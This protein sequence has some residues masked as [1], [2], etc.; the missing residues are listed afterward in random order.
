MECV[1]G[2]VVHPR[3]RGLR[4]DDDDH[5]PLAHQ[6]RSGAFARAERSSPS[7]SRRRRPASSSTR[8]ARARRSPASRPR[9]ST[10][11]RCRSCTR[12]RRRRWTCSPS[13]VPIRHRR[14]AN[15]CRA[16]S[17][18]V[19]SRSSRRRSSARRTSRCHSQPTTTAELCASDR[20]LPR[21]ARWRASIAATSA[22]KPRAGKLDFEDLLGAGDPHLRDATRRPLERFTRALPRLHRR[23]VPGRQP[24]PADAARPL[25]RR[26]RRPLRRR[27]RLP[28][29]LRASPAPRP[30]YLLGDAH[31]LRAGRRSIRL[32]RNYRSTP[33]VLELANRL[34]P[35]LGGVPK[36]LP[37]RRARRSRCRR[38]ERYD[39]ARAK[40][41]GRRGGSSGFIAAGMPPREIACSTAIKARSTDYELALACAPASRSRWRRRLPASARRCARLLRRLRLAASTES[42]RAWSACCARGR[43]R[44]RARSGRAESR[45]AHT[46]AVDLARLRRRWPRPSR[47]ASTP[48]ASSSPTCASAS[49][50]STP[51][52]TPCACSTYHLAKGLEWDAVFLP[53]LEERELPFFRALESGSVAEE[54]RLF[55]VGLTRARTH[56]FLT[57]DRHRK[58]SRFIDELEPDGPRPSRESSR[59]RRATCRAPREGGRGAGRPSP[60][61]SPGCATTP[62]GRSSGRHDRAAADRGAF[63][64]SVGDGRGQR[65][66]RL[67]LGRRRAPRTRRRRRGGAADAATRARRSWTSAASRR[68]PA[69]A[70][71]RSTRS[72]AASFPC[73]RG[74]RAL[75]VSIDT[76]KAEVARR[77]LALGAELVNDVTAL[78]GDPELAA[79]VADGGRLR[80]PHAHA[81]RAA[82]DAGRPALRRRRRP[83]SRRSSRSGWR[84]PSPRASR[85]ERVCLDPGIGFGKTVAHNLE[86]VRR[87]DELV[88][89]GR[90]VVVGF[91]RKSSLGRILGDPTATTGTLAASVG[92]AVAAF[93]RGATI[94]RVHDVREHVEALRVARGGRRMT[95]ELRGLELFGHHGVG[96]EERERGQLSSTT[97]SS[98]SASAARD[99]RIEDAVDY[100][101]VA[102]TVR[103]VSAEPRFALLEALS[104]RDRRRARRAVRA[105][106][107]AACASAS[108]RCARP[109]STS[110]SRP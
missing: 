105:R 9:R 103:E 106:A 41:L 102:A 18:E 107:G 81:R 55:Y 13:K 31:A 95:I 80:L 67:V 76:S 98:R 109:A 57:W 37:R 32:E 53:R 26:P 88:A 96:E 86:L 20:P 34:A 22:L 45:R 28:G 48:S 66:A 85:E 77:A 33:Q 47:T 87:L 75:P 73:S 17:C 40:L 70:A 61:S 38:C 78:R 62:G 5:A 27:R 99:D 74:S 7:P 101:E 100:R 19:R 35:A 52:R 14:C 16:V 84:S 1:H 58:R 36:P 60:R 2:P 90:P 30:R 23:R 24:A 94:L 11:R 15:G 93:D 108:R 104:T 72:C 79:V 39:D 42:S 50:A 82:D 54:R 8:L 49:T 46:P 10:R 83:R 71:S 51:P 91:S 12:A 44:R 56:L 3:R 29:D 4:Q 63:P 43:L 25:A 6:V 89:I 110:S 97:S 68:G 92:A 21:R 65:H 59:P 64:A 69:P